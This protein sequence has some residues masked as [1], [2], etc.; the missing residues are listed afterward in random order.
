LT[1]FSC[2]D[3]YAG[4]GRNRFSVYTLRLN[5]RIPAAGTL[6]GKS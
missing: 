5:R 4:S 6:T 2:T 1:P 3:Y